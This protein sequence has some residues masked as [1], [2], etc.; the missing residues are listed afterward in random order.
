MNLK[1][2]TAIITGASSGNG[3]AIALTFAREGCNVV[4]A[5]RRENLLQEVAKD[6]EALGVKALPIRTDVTLRSDVEKLFTEAITI[7]GQIDILVNNAGVLAMGEYA[8]TPWDICEQ[9]VRTNLIGSMMTAHYAVKHFKENNA[10]MIIHMN[11]LSA[12]LPT[13]FV[14]AYSA[15]KVGLRGFSEALRHELSSYQDIHI[16]DVYATFLDTTGLDHAA[17]FM[18]K[19]LVPPPPLVDPCEIAE[20]MVELVRN[21][22]HSVTVGANAHLGKI[23]YL[24]APNLVGSVLNKI[25]RLYKKIGPAE[26]DS[27]GNLKAPVMRGSTVHGGWMKMGIPRV[28]NKIMKLPAL[29]RHKNA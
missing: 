2:A 17:N 4:L 22:Q 10:G 3:K 18:G 29:F 27:R 8:E 9:A 11:S 7:T 13:P 25:F 16:S 14:V 1:G 26:D 23:A 5:A 6:C 19:K 15:G 24:I 20:V 12:F 21:P 28:L